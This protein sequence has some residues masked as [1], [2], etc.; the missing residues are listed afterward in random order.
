M[1]EAED[2]QPH[3]APR[4]RR[5]RRSTGRRVQEVPSG[6]WLRWVGMAL[7]AA[8]ICPLAQAFP[9]LGAGLAV[10][11]LVLIG[12]GLQTRD[13]IWHRQREQARDFLV[14]GLLLLGSAALALTLSSSRLSDFL[15]PPAPRGEPASSVPG[16]PAKSWP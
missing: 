4:V 5:R 8:G 11:G 15:S 16:V 1:A 3:D 13:S 7:V 10:V 6:R 9:P 12:R 14:G 2:S